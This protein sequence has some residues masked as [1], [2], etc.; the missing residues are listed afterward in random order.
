MNVDVLELLAAGGDLATLAVCYVLW[1]L[2]RRLLKVELHLFPP[3]TRVGG[4]D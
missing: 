2:D 1:R 3:R 4:T